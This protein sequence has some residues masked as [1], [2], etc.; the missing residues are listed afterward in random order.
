MV[1]MSFGFNMANEF[2]F[3]ITEEHPL[4]QEQV[5]KVTVEARLHEVEISPEMYC[6][7]LEEA[8]RSVI[9]GHQTAGSPE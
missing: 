7:V 1:L 4:V 3:Q 5:E 9:T 2:R 8:I 6:S